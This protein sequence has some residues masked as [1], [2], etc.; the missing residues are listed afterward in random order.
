M[1]IF[2]RESRRMTQK[3][4]AEASHTTQASVSRAEAGVHEPLPSTVEAWSKALRYPIEF[5]AHRSEAPPLPR[6]FWR[7]QVKLGKIDQKEIEATIGIRCL[8]VQALARSVELSEP[9]VPGITI[10]VDAGSSMEAARFLRAHWRLPRG[11]IADLVHLVESNGVMVV[12]LPGICGFQGVSIRDGRKDLP[13]MIFVSADDPADRQRWTIA[14]E[15]G[16]IVLHHHLPATSE[17]SEDE[18]DHF[19]S[20]FLAPGHEIR[21]QFSWKTGLA[22][23]A[24]LKLHWRMSMAALLVRGHALGR[25]PEQSY[26]RLWREMSKAGYRR[27]EPN[28]LAPEHPTMLRELVRVHV[29]DLGFTIEELATLLALDLED[30]RTDFLNEA[31]RPRQVET[32]VPSKPQLRLVD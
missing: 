13:P 2:A 5:F 18:A 24:Q 17:W 20:E 11:P 29:E 16:H 9:D 27:N 10:G 30:V 28:E 23:L 26:T 22:E 1:L 7:K 21:H 12:P 8:N 15:L 32:Q 31:P 25:I 19:A 4:L 6:C 14:H 3:T